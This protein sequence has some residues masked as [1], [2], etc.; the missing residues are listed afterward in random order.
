MKKSLSSKLEKNSMLGTEMNLLSLLLF[1][2]NRSVKFLSQKKK[3][4][5]V[6]PYAFKWS[7]MQLCLH[8]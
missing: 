1:L 5:Q 6:M 8:Q 4:E 3:T 7:L 2:S